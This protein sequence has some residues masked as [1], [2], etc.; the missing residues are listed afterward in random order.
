MNAQVPDLWQANEDA[1]RLYQLYLVRLQMSGAYERVIAACDQIRGFAA[2][3]PGR[4]EGLFTFMFELDALCALKKYRTAWR[5][6]RLQEEIATGAR[7]DIIAGK[8]EPRELAWFE[9]NHA[10][11]LFFLGRDDEGCALLEAWLDSCINGG[12]A[13][14][15]DLMFRVYNGDQEPK[16]R[17]RVTLTHFYNRLSKSLMEWQHWETFVT[18]FP[19]ALFRRSS[20]SRLDLLADSSRLAT[21]FAELLTLRSKRVTSGVTRGQSDL[22][23]SAKTVKKSQHR[24][25]Q[26]IAACRRRTRTRREQ[27]DAKLHELFPDLREF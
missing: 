17:C 26:E 21:F 5:Q 16:N 19:S 15:F 7:V 14:C 6:L 9:F 20:I 8:W 4:A 2:T 13:P 3:G 22:V 10:P 27:V 23:E 18:G 24:I 1:P 25:K 12:K 11:L